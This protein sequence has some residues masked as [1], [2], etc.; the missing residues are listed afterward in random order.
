MPESIGGCSALCG[1]SSCFTL[2]HLISRF[3]FLD[4]LFLFI[5]VKEEMFEPFFGLQLWKKCL[6]SPAVAHPHR[7]P[8]KVFPNL[9]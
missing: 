5:C 3:S 2:Y 4:N 9:L 1:C 8:H 6:A 7:Q